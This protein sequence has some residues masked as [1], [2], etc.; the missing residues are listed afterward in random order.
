MDK[1][2][3][4]LSNIK[5]TRERKTFLVLIMINAPQKQKPEAQMSGAERFNAGLPFKAPS[6]KVE[7]KLI[8]RTRTGVIIEE[9]INAVRIRLDSGDVIALHNKDQ[10]YRL[11]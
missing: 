3:N 1:I 5:L 2:K 7:V 8:G 9:L 11:I 10:D 4:V 6:K